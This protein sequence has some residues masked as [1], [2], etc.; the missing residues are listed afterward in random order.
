MAFK[1]WSPTHSVAAPKINQHH[2]RLLAI[3]E[4]LQQAQRRGEPRNVL[5]AALE[6]L[7]NFVIAHFYVEE[8][9]L[10]RLNYPRLGEHMVQHRRLILQIEA[11]CNKFEN[12]DTALTIEATDHLRTGLED[13]I[14]QTHGRDAESPEAMPLPTEMPQPNFQRADF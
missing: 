8:E 11:L 12:D 3:A 14:I 13:H 2:R 5:A 1:E 4:E 7:T 9:M 6:H 10:K